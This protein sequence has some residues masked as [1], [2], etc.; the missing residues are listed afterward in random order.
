MAQ[1]TVK[2]KIIAELPERGGTS[3]NGK[4]WRSKEY[5]I[6][7]PGQYVKNV[8]FSVLGDNIDT[9]GLSVGQEVEIE[10]DI[11]AREHNGKW[12]NSIKCWKAQITGASPTPQPQ[13]YASEVPADYKPRETSKPAESPFND[14]DDGLPF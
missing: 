7:E 6:T 12:Y 14:N 9:F 2:G 13:S 1:L 11:D 5:V 3:K 4:D 8:C 10:C